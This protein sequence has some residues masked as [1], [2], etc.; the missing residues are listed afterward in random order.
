[1]RQ[2]AATLGNCTCSSCVSE[3]HCVACDSIHG[4]S[5][6]GES[7]G[8]TCYLQLDS[9]DS[10]G[11]PNLL[12]AAL[13]TPEHCAKESGGACTLCEDGY[14]LQNNECKKCTE[15][16]LH[17]TSDKCYQCNKTIDEEGNEVQYYLST[18]EKKCVD[19][20]KAENDED[21]VRCK[22]GN[23]FNV[24]NMRCEQCPVENC[25]LCTNAT[26]CYQCKGKSL[27]NRGNGVD[28]CVP[29]KNCVSE[30]L[31]EDHCE[32]CESGYRLESGG[33]TKCPPNCSV[34]YYD[35]E[36]KKEM[37]TTCDD[38]YVIRKGTCHE[39]KELHCS[40]GHPTYGCL[41][42]ENHYF[43]NSD[44]DC[45]ECS[46]ACETCVSS[47]DHCL[48]C[49]EGSY[50][51]KNQTTQC[52]PKDGHC[53]LVDQAGCKE[54]DNNLSLVEDLEENYGWYVPEGEQTCQRC[55]DH[56][57]LCESNNDP[58][59]E[60]RKKTP[61]V[62]TACVTGFLL[63]PVDSSGERKYICEKMGESCNSTEMGY[64]TKC[65]EGYFISDTDCIK[66]DES[67]ASCETNSS[68][69][70]CNE[71]YYLPEG[72]V[73][74]TNVCESV[75]KISMT[76]NKKE[77]GS[78]NKE[79]CVDCNYGYYKAD[80]KDKNCTEC[81][82]ECVKCKRGEDGQPRCVECRNDTN[83]LTMYYDEG[84]KKCVS[85]NNIEHCSYCNDT[86]CLTC[87]DG[88]SKDGSGT[89][90]HKTPVGAIVGGV[91][92]FIVVVIIII[93]VIIAVIWWRRSK[94]VKKEST[95]IKPFHVD[96]DLEL[97]L[98]GADN[99]KFPLKTNKWNLVFGL[100][101]AKALLD[102]PYTEEVSL[103]NMSKKNYY[104]EFHNSPS[105]RYDLEIEP[106]SAT[107]KP[108]TAITVKFT[109]TMKCT[110]SVSDHLAIS[111][112]DVDNLGQETARFTVVIES[113]LSMKLDHT[114]LKPQMPP[115]GEG[116]FGMVFKGTYRGRDVAIKKMKSRTLSIEQEKEF[117]HEVSMLTQLRHQCVVELIGAVYTEGEISIVTEFAEY[118]SLSKMW[119][120]HE[121]SYQLKVKYLD[122]M[123]VAL[124]YLHQNQIL[125]RDVKGENLLVFSLNPNSPV[126]A[127][128]T[129]F[130][131]CRNISDRNI[132]AKELT[133]GVG[134]P[135]YMAPECLKNVDDYSYPI[136]VY[137]YGMVM[138]ETFTE[139][140]SYENDERFNQPWL[141][142]Q[143]VIEGN[144]LDK[145]NG[146]PDNYWDLLTKCWAQNPEERPSF[147][148][149]LQ[150]IES[151]GEDI[152][153][154]LRN[155]GDKKFG[156]I[157]ETSSTSTPSV[158]SA[159]KD[160]SSTNKN[161]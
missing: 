161:D 91:V 132:N 86:G 92:A 123:A 102:T 85:C 151:W 1:M 156:G 107:L 49:A 113:D 64:C 136:D 40:S 142:P 104:F 157:S 39:Q 21:C 103:A 153:Y 8:V 148:Q 68:C 50:F 95:A 4:Q 72:A 105:H 131:T 29:I 109:I 87:E 59:E 47:K 15:N 41:E 83:G 7:G 26:N 27:L 125:H 31:K 120:K 88:Y 98:L 155:E 100:E 90:C 42:C 101:K 52:V 150:I 66:C 96:S 127:K 79:G 44:L 82:E 93:V 81:P 140:N 143:F 10:G 78:Y 119:G 124:S 130:G 13:S 145:P 16:C 106:K 133:H 24:E 77:G 138:Y 33:C 30:Y 61:V 18:D 141:I 6:S 158:P 28:S 122:D 53:K 11:I 5:E 80:D 135:A 108:S 159:A 34:C 94:F 76:C 43:F 97:L 19:C 121:L 20:S 139:K 99:E 147:T 75:D 46:S 70:Q 22:E 17:C 115:I 89:K 160:P 56:C 146:I 128:L 126:C 23:Y 73:L 67:C 63:T 112:M 37:C 137:A 129:D 32:L 25:A 45:E 3:S 149:V 57:K 14:Y 54:C 38:G 51:D 116:A 74:G 144:R 12:C 114:E 55:I 84:A 48:S 58:D 9:S 117:N 65:N 110:A 134:T 2:D 71:G 36:N 152:R 60:L 69:I 62:C 154:A 118:G 35:E 111:A